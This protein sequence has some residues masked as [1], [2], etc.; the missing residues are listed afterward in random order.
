MFVEVDV[1]QRALHLGHALLEELGELILIL[2]VFSVIAAHVFLGDEFG[3]FIERFDGADILLLIFFLIMYFS[4]IG[5][6]LR[7]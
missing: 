5:L 4:D 2:L 3:S 1:R 7:F 6:H